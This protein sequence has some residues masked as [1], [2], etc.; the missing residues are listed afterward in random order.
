MFFILVEFEWV[1]IGILSILGI[2]DRPESV[3]VI[4]SLDILDFSLDPLIYWSF[5]VSLKDIEMLTASN[6]FTGVKLQTYQSSLF[7]SN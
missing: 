2:V 5:P 1:L 4:M 7:Y 3:Y 6:S